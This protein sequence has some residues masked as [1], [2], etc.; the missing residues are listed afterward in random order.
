MIAI[1]V[2]SDHI[3]EVN[4]LVTALNV[5]TDVGLADLALRTASAQI[6]GCGLALEPLEEAAGVYVLVV[7]FAGA[8]VGG[9]VG[10][11]GEAD[12]AVGPGGG[13]VVDANVTFVSLFDSHDYYLLYV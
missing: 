1:D 5:Q 12:A 13:W 11:F 7:A 9:L 6:G 2:L 3:T 4:A 8:V 10:D